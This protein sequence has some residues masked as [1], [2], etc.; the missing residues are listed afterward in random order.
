MVVMPRRTVKSESCGSSDNL[1][2]YRTPHKPTSTHI[3]QTNQISVPPLPLLLLLLVAVFT[4]PVLSQ[5]QRTSTNPDLPANFPCASGNTPVILS[6]INTLTVEVQL[7][8]IDPTCREVNFGTIP[9]SSGSATF[10]S[11]TPQSSHSNPSNPQRGEVLLDTFVGHGWI[12]RNLRSTQKP[13]MDTFIVGSAPNQTWVIGSNNTQNNGGVGGRDGAGVAAVASPSGGA[14]GGG[15]GGL[16]F[17]LLFLG[18]GIAFAIMGAAVVYIMYRNLKQRRRA[19]EQTKG[20]TT[21]KNTISTVREPVAKDEELGDTAGF[22]LVSSASAGTVE[23]SKSVRDPDALTINT[24]MSASTLVHSPFTSTPKT[25]KQPLPTPDPDAIRSATLG[26][27]RPPQLA[28]NTDYPNTTPTESSKESLAPPPLATA[29]TT[30]QMRSIYSRYDSGPLRPQSTISFQFSPLEGPHNSV[31][32]WPSITRSSSIRTD[33]RSLSERVNGSL[34]PPLSGLSGPRTYSY[35]TGVPSLLL[36][37][38]EGGHTSVIH[39]GGT[40]KVKYPHAK[41][42]EDEV[43]THAGDVVRIHTLYDDGWALVTVDGRDVAGMVPVATLD[44][45]A[46]LDLEPAQDTRSELLESAS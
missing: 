45:G 39:K 41:N 17:G 22:A 3:A 25:P 33:S 36:N 18:L 10:N 6:A 7:L 29:S 34:A 20:K 14:G 21:M 44:T 46:A 19:M 26:Q 37:T 8:W 30:S 28:V 35:Q 4:S 2:S 12:V 1:Q 23:R 38:P 16:L 43:E 27:I 13:V 42:M 24:S 40:Y 5:P 15:S 9:P 11:T 31:T 32:R